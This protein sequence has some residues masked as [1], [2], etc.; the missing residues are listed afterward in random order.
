MRLA[1]ARLG[2]RAESLKLNSAAFAVPGAQRAP[3]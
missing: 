2:Y 1:K 3:F